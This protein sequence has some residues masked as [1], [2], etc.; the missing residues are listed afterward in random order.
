MSARDRTRPTTTKEDRMGNT[1]KTLDEIG[2]HMKARWLLLATALIIIGF[3]LSGPARYAL[4]L[5][6]VMINLA[7]LANGYRLV[8]RERAAWQ[9][10]STQL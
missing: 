1:M 7:S 2:R 10:K 5:G 8:R 6:G 4:V 9:A 3:M